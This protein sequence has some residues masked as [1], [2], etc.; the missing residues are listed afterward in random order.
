MAVTGG[1]DHL[2]VSVDIDVLDPAHAP[3]VGWQEPGG[4]TTRQLLDFLVALAPRASGLALNGVNPMTDHRS[5]TSILAA[6]LIFQF[7]VAAGRGD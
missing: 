5:Q 1:A 6:N 4:L 3:G 7:A 2:F